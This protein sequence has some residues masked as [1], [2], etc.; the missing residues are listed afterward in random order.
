M[1]YTVTYCRLKPHIPGADPE[2]APG[3]PPKIGKHIIF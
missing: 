1:R 2:D 3:A